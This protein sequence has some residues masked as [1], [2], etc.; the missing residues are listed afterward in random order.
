MKFLCY[1][2]NIFCHT[3]QT[4]RAGL[5]VLL[6]RSPKFSRDF[7]FYGFAAEQNG[8]T[9]T[10]IPTLTLTITPKLFITLTTTLHVADVFLK[11]EQ[12]RPT[13]EHGFGCPLGMHA[14]KYMFFARHLLVHVVFEKGPYEKYMFFRKYIRSKKHMFF[15]KVYMFFDKVYIFFKKR[16]FFS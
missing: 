7:G 10:L 11:M 16:T 4:C 6:I 8:F 9:Y 12:D 3:L 1:Q 5:L 2:C 14:E 13:R 15:R